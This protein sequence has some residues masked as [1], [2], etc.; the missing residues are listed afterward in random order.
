MGVYSEENHLKNSIES[1]LNQSYKEF[2][3][4]II[5]DG[6]TDN[7]L[8]II[9]EYAKRDKRIKVI[10]NPL[11]IGL[12][13]SLNKGIRI[14]QGEFI[15]RQDAHDFS[16]PHRLEKQLKFLQKNS[17]YAFCGSNI[18]VKQNKEFSLKFFELDEI[19][20]NLIIKNCFMHSTIFLRRK[21][22]E[23][24][25]LY[26]QKYIYAQDYELWCR[27]IYKY[28]LKAKN[29]NEKLVV[30]NVP[31][32][33]LMAEKKYLIQRKNI[34]K[35]KLKYLKYVKNLFIILKVVI[36]ISKTSFYFFA[37][38]FNLIKINIGGR[39]SKK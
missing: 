5:D 33:F 4:I 11:N 12:T 27:L 15:A 9:K 17:D 14:A 3:F 39:I 38:Y 13:K 31:L 16:L 8:E 19:R 2:E 37:F 20:K 35:T 10:K 29:L 24:Y 30:M 32:K 23:K 18:I 26:N 7:S 6:S 1:I 22:Y 25:G 21:I 28:H 34:I 36:S